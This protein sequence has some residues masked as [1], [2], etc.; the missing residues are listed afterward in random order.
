MWVA[1]YSSSD[2]SH[3]H[4]QSCEVRGFGRSWESW[5]PV[6]WLTI[7]CWNFLAI[8]SHQGRVREGAVQIFRRWTSPFVC[9]HVTFIVLFTTFLSPVTRSRPDNNSFFSLYQNMMVIAQARIQLA[10]PYFGRFWQDCMEYSLD[11]PTASQGETAILSSDCWFC[12]NDN[13]NMTVGGL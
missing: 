12:N 5:N 11:H 8:S 1:K 4:V 2:L 3:H 13:C 7:G 10:C 9:M 6:V